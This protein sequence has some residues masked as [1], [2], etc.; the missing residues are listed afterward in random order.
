M[1]SDSS[2]P[3]ADDEWDP[4]FLH[5]RREAIVIF[6]TWFAAL[7]WAVPFCYVNGYGPDVDTS[8][9]TW[10]I[11]SWLFWGIL[12]PWIVADVFATWFCFCYMK[13]DDLGTTPE[14]PAADALDSTP[15]SAKEVEA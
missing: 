15:E 14:G 13:N 1:N 9:T 8:N 7:I 5:A 10:G 3:I 6:F 2:P 11:P 4:T 12:V